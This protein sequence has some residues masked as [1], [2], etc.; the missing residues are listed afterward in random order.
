MAVPAIKG[1]ETGKS[2]IFLAAVGEGDLMAQSRTANLIRIARRGAF[3]F[4]SQN[5]HKLVPETHG[6]PESVAESVEK[7]SVN[8]Q[9]LY[10]FG[11]GSGSISFKALAI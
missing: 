6:S 9:P 5:A 1:F 3:S 10:C 8:A 7:R 4:H 2:V 11:F